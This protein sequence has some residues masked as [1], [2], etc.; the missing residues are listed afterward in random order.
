MT[1]FRSAVSSACASDISAEQAV[2]PRRVMFFMVEAQAGAAGQGGW[3]R[4][5]T[6]NKMELAKLWP[7]YSYLS[8]YDTLPL[9]LVNF[10]VAPI[11]RLEMRPISQHPALLCMPGDSFPLAPCE[12][13]VKKW[14]TF[15]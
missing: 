1:L 15:F 2:V 12:S 9:S 8:M 4:D 6:A 5:G 14:E 11:P 10:P 7:N 13:Q 3:R